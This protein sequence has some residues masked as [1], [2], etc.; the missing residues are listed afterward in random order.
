MAT[1]TTILATDIIAASRVTI[2]TNFA[3]LNADKVDTGST[4]ANPAWLTSVAG[5]KII[6][7]V[8][9]FAHLPAAA[10]NTGMMATVT[11]ASA[12]TIGTTVA[13]G[14]ANTV[15]VWSNGSNWRIFAS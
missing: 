9:A 4:Y 2:N 15:L 5:A 8:Y 14:G 12:T 10:G 1:I 3:N 13:G 7:A 6:P 11:D